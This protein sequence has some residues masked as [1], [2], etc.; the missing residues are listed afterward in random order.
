MSGRRVVVTGV[1]AVSPLG[2]GREALWKSASEGG[3]ARGADRLEVEASHSDVMLALMLRRQREHRGL[4]LADM[5][6]VE[7]HEAFAAQVACNLRA[8]EQGWKE[9]AVGSVDP[10]RLNV[11]GSSIAL[12]H[13]FAATGGRIVTTLAR[14]MQRRGVRRGLASIC[15]A[16]GM[17]AAVL[18]ERP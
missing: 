18:L 3:V 4:T 2:L 11:S 1:G 8:W 15:A 17:A 12:G 13:P 6:L 7:V 16:G 9:P 10:D 14:E 5:D